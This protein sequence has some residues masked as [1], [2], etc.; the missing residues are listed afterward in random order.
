MSLVARTYNSHQEFLDTVIKPFNARVS[1][2]L[3]PTIRGMYADGDMVSVSY[4]DMGGTMHAASV[5]VTST[6]M[7]K[8]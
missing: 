2:P 6:N 5:R 4:H 7:M 1:K 8:K 3:V